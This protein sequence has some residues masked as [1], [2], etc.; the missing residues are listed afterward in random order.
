MTVFLTYN[1]AKKTFRGF[2]ADAHNIV[3]Q[4]KNEKALLKT[5]RSTLKEKH[6]HLKLPAGLETK[7]VDWKVFH[8]VFERVQ[9]PSDTWEVVEF[10][11]LDVI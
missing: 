10:N 4:A 3:V 8:S 9:I 6:P 1:K 2:H 11:P 7:P 5:L